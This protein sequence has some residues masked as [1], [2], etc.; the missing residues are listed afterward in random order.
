MIVPQ[1]STVTPLPTTTTLSYE[2]TESTTGLTPSNLEGDLFPQ[3]GSTDGA[4]LPATTITTAGQP[5]IVTDETETASG[6]KALP[7][8]TPSYAGQ[9]LQPPPSQRTHADTQT[10]SEDFEGSASADEEGSGQDVYPL[11]TALVITTTTSTMMMPPSYTMLPL[12]SG[13]TK[14]QEGLGSGSGLDQYSG[15][16][17]T[18]GDQEGSGEA[19][20]HGHLSYTVLPRTTIPTITVTVKKQTT[21][22]TPTRGMNAKDQTTQL[23]GNRTAQTT[24]VG[25]TQVEQTTQLSTTQADKPTQFSSNQRDQT[26]QSSS[27]QRDQTTKDSTKVDHVHHYTTVPKEPTSIS[28]S[29]AHSHM[30][31]PTTQSVGQMTPSEEDH[32]A[33]STTTTP[34]PPPPTP[35][36]HH[37][38]STTQQAVTSEPS[39]TITTSTTTTSSSLPEEEF[40]DYNRKTEE[41]PLLESKPMEEVL[42]HSVDVR[43]MADIV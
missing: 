31:D 20:P 43:G 25:T 38:R 18:S 12:G 3:E 22:A 26:T 8:Y 35:S 27:N 17:E 34:P 39:T 33:L 6:G 36:D 5:P 19:A 28:S 10:E 9:T 42:D 4:L 24:Q 15:D 13:V 40:M 14:G 29:T 11:E 32:P 37:T 7:T 23:S 2:D 41:E 21:G 30:L 1:S 16:E